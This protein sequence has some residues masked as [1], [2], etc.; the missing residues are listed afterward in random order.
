VGSFKLSNDPQFAEKLEDIIGHLN[1]PE[2]AL[3]WSLDEKSQIQ[4]LDRTQ[5]GLPLKKGRSQTMTHDYKRHGTTTLFAALKVAT[6]GVPG[7]CMNKH[8]HH[9]WLRFLRLLDRQTPPELDLH[10]IVDNFATHKHDKVKRWLETIDFAQEHD[11][12]WIS[13]EL[14]KAHLPVLYVMG[15]DDLVELSPADDSFIPINHRRVE[16]DGL[17]FVGCQYSLPF[18][19]GANEKREEEIASDVV[20]LQNLVDGETVLVTHSLIQCPLFPGLVFGENSKSRDHRHARRRRHR[21]VHLPAVD[22]SRIAV[23]YRLPMELAA[24]LQRHSQ[25]QSRQ[26]DAMIGVHS[27]VNVGIRPPAGTS[28][29]VGYRRPMLPR[30]ARTG[31]AQTLNRPPS[32]RDRVNESC[33]ISNSVPLGPP[34]SRLR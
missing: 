25:N 20:G 16:H 15:N 17:G 22:P 11:A 6:G 7:T 30:P 4:A 18:M 12:R 1:P 27:E 13:S 31:N 14:Q 3:V 9:E 19:G 29:V 33:S 32:R 2:H 24:N 8:R 26:F 28:C 34:S 23:G 10:L 5:P 21:T